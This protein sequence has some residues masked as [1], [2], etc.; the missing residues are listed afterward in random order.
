MWEVLVGLLIAAC[1]GMA[2][3]RMKILPSAAVCAILLAGSWITMRLIFQARSYLLSPLFPT[4][5]VV[6]NYAV[7]TIFKTW[8]IQ[9]VVREVADST[10]ILLKSSEENLNSIIKAVPDII[11]R[12][13]SAGRIIFISPAIAKYTASP[14]AL[15]GQP[16]LPLIKTEYHDAFVKLT[17]DVFQ[18]ESGNLDLEAVGLKGR[19]VWLSTHVMAFRNDAE[20][21][22]SLLGIA[23]D[24]TDR[25]LAENALVEKQLQLEEINMHLEQR[26]ADAVSDLRKKDQMLI[27]QGR[28][29]AMGEM[30][31][32]IAHQWRQPLN[33]VGLI[34]QELLMDYDSDEFNKE[35][36]EASVKEAME[37]IQNMSQT[38][39]DFTNYFKPDKEKRPFNAN[40]AV[41]KTLSLV[42]TSLKNMDINIEVIVTD[43]FDING[44]AN[45]YSQ[46]LLN[47]LLNCK[48]AFE[49]SNINRQRV[50]TITVFKENNKS[51]VTIADNAGGIPEDIVDKIFDPY[52]TTKGPDKGTGI[53][54]Y[55]AK[56]IIEKNMGGSI[57]V[58]NTTDGA[59]FRVEV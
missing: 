15:I 28:Q 50:I 42:E 23:S 39:N 11:F 3:A 54:L 1:S 52:F 30:I 8:K 13:D 37:L 32:N 22:V 29:A 20:E 58:R 2:I 14:D 45:E 40:Q 36:L 53:G 9:L 41:A 56:A 55:M 12:L 57:I 38:I 26:V 6:L 46:V 24:I 27:Q 7:L 44:Y 16:L 47:I 48:D 59:E 33:V 43:D 35:T 10:L 17:N 31:G 21:I 4:A 51:V 5:L 49:G 34:L 18:G 25:K 19:H